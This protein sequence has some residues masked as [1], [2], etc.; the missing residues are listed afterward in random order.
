MYQCCIF[1][2]DGT[3]IDTIESITHSVNLTMKQVGMGAVD[4][5]HVK[6]FVGD[7]FKKLVERS[8]VYLGDEKLLHYD[9]A[10]DIYE[11]VFE[12]NCLYKIKPYDGILDLLL[13]L[14]E[15]G[16][17][18]AV[19]TNKSHERGMECV[20]SCFGTGFFDLITGEGNGIACKPD[21]AGAFYT[22][23]YFHVS[24]SRCLYLGDTNTDMKTGIA[25]GMDTVAVT[26]G[27]RKKEELMKFNPKYMADHPEKIKEIFA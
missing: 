10:L 27:F 26:W 6:V 9:E 19:L 12:E 8:L 22:A 4:Q 13:F 2:L 11:K 3:I 17:K 1:D 18:I 7:G 16:I 20:E 5:D 21:P 24:P 25:A 14:K 15:R 23:D